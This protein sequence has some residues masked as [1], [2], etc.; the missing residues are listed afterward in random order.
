MTD[1]YHHKKTIVIHS[2]FGLWTMFEDELDIAPREL[3]ARN[4]VVFLFCKGNQNIV[5][6]GGRSTWQHA[7]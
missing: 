6:A 2:A 7:F 3:D 1:G 4:K 5:M